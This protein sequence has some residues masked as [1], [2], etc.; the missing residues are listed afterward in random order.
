M[1]VR[2]IIPIN[3]K[4]SRIIFDDNESFA[5]YKGEMRRLDIEVGREIDEEEYY[6]TIYPT[7]KREPLRDFYIYWKGRS[8]RRM[9]L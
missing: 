4:K 1:I 2:E 3:T 5:L 7:L 8:S 9:T 6:V